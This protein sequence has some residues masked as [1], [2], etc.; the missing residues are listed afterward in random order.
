MP[1]MTTIPTIAFQ[2]TRMTIAAITAT[3][4]ISI[5][6]GALPTVDGAAGPP[7][8]HS[9]VQWTSVGPLKQWARDRGVR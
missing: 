4:T 3:T 1:L 8:T 6:S 5:G 7:S 2:K 9:D